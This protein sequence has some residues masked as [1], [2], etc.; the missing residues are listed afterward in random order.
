MTD[1]ELINYLQE[2]EA[3]LISDD[4]GHWA[5]TQWG[6]TQWGMQNV[7]EN[8]PVDIQTTFFIEAHEWKKTIREAI[9]AYKAEYD[10]ANDEHIHH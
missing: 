5:V 10:S 4:E 8:P 3:S 2:T 9:E 1:T 7:S 6:M